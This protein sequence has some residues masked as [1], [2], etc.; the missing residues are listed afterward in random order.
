MYN[1]LCLKFISIKLKFSFTYQ[2]DLGYLPLW[3][4]GSLF[5]LAFLS[6]H[7]EIAKKDTCLI[8][9][10]RFLGIWVLFKLVLPINYEIQPMKI[11]VLLDV[12]TNL[13]YLN[14][15]VLGKKSTFYCGS[16]PISLFFIIFFF[17][18]GLWFE[19]MAS[20]LQSRCS[21]AWV[22]SSVHFALVIF[23]DG[24]L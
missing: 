9:V 5:T 23:R 4:E 21:T 3:V 12:I 19:L 1:Y 2:I 22:T 20:C 17:I 13:N 15:C 14:Y 18:V 8:S 24:G 11:S 7:T 6:S 16:R 10:N